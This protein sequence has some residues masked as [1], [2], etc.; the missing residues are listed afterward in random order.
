MSTVRPFLWCFPFLFDSQFIMSMRSVSWLLL[1]LL[2]Q[3]WG[4]A[5]TA[6]FST[7][8]LK[9][10]YEKTIFLRIVKKAVGHSMELVKD[11]FLL[12]EFALSQGG[13]SAILLQKAPYM[14]A[15]S[16]IYW[17]EKW[18]EK[19]K[20]SFPVD[21]FHNFG[22]YSHSFGH[23][24]FETSK[25]GSKDSIWEEWAYSMV[26]FEHYHPNTSHFPNHQGSHFTWSTQNL[27]S[28]L[29]IDGKCQLSCIPIH[30]I[31]LGNWISSAVGYSNCP[32][33]YGK[34]QQ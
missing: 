8:K 21:L 30:T 32:P 18:F 11:I 9:K 4:D 2:S 17:F 31:W 14:S 7:D 19:Y 33:I 23:E 20:L 1:T 24:Q 10:T 13:I 25:Q 27:Q 29:R 34:L 6:D 3:G 15:V 5:G 16:W 12:C 22:F 28:L 26:S